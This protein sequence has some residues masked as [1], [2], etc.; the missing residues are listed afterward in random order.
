MTMSNNPT[1]LLLGLLLGVMILLMGSIM[2]FSAPRAPDPL[3]NT[4]CKQNGIVTYKGITD[5][6]HQYKRK[7]SFD[8]QNGIH[9]NI[10]AD[11][12]CTWSEVK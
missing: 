10:P 9:Y 5:A 12:Q 8:D 6:P 4:I 7:T 3:F 11:H 2:L 1:G